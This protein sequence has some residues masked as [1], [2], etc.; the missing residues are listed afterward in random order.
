MGSTEN[1][2]PQA[3]TL[4]PMIALS[5]SEL[6]RIHMHLLLYFLPVKQAILVVRV[7]ASP[8]EYVNTSRQ[9]LKKG[10]V[11]S[12]H[13]PILAHMVDSEHRADP[14]EASCVIYKVPPNYPK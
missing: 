11:K 5:S 2:K 7:S 9:G 1:P 13:S 14:N 8:Q 12:M 6:L 10:E 4:L 3:S